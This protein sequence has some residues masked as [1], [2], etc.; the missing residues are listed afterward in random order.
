MCLKFC[1]CCLLDTLSFSNQHKN[2][3]GHALGHPRSPIIMLLARV[4]SPCP[5]MDKK[6]VDISY[7]SHLSHQMEYSSAI[8]TPLHPKRS[9]CTG[10]GFPCRHAPCPLSGQQGIPPPSRWP[11]DR[12]CPSQ[13]PPGPDR[14][15]FTRKNMPQISNA[16]VAFR[17]PHSPDVRAF[18]NLRRLCTVPN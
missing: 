14:T 9:L 15:N 16:V 8:F 17:V 2:T 11:T 3:K 13:A 10:A 6:T 1:V 5:L 4:V 7:Q 12:T 18:R